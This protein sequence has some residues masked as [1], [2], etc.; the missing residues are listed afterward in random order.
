VQASRNAQPHP[1]L[2]KAV[3]ARREMLLDMDKEHYSEQTRVHTL[4][5]AA[6]QLGFDL[7]KDCFKPEKWQWG[8]RLDQR[9]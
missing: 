5:K 3:L 9:D 8:T 2:T 1:G 7:E 4:Q 6:Q